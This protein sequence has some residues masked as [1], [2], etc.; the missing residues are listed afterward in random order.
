MAVVEE[1]TSVDQMNCIGLNMYHVGLF[2]HIA[3]WNHF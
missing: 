2:F 3:L 1:Y